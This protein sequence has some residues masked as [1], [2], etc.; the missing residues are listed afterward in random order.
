MKKIL[1]TAMT[2]SISEVMET[3]FYLPVEFGEESTLLQSGMEKNRPNMACKLE[4]AGDFSGHLTLVIPKNLLAEMTENFMGESRENLEEEHLSGTLTEML[5]M[6][7][8]NA[9]SRIDSK[10]PFKLNIP[11]VIEESE[12]PKENLFIIIETT[13]SMMAIHITVD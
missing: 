9:L 6:I 13:Q 12:I 2:T 3:M 5:N 4:F 7:C 8:G 11:Q 1:M 10:T